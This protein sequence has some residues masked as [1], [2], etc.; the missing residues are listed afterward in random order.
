MVCTMT[1][2]SELKF[3]PKREALFFANRDSFLL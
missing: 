2:V 1:T 3:E